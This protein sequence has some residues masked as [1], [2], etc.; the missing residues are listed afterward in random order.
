MSDDRWDELSK[1]TDLLALHLVLDQVKT[2]NVEVG[3]IDPK[4]PDTATQRAARQR[5]AA[6][7]ATSRGHRRRNVRALDRALDASPYPSAEQYRTRPVAEMAR[8]DATVAELCNELHK[9]DP[10]KFTVAYLSE[11]YGITP[12]NTDS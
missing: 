2:R 11:R 4:V 1:E 10:E 6:S 3:P 7:R 8:R 12:R 5:Q 9:L